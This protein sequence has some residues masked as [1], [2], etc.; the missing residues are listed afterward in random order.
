[1]QHPNTHPQHTQ[2]TLLYSHTTHAVSYLLGGQPTETSN[3]AA[4]TTGTRLKY[5]DINEVV[6]DTQV[7]FSTDTCA[8][9]N[10]E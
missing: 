7:F 5:C 2:T 10:R 6:L 3:A 9:I 4:A 8:F 1:M